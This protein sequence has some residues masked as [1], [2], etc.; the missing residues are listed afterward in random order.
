MREFAENSLQ[1]FFLQ[2]PRRKNAQ[3]TPNHTLN[4]KNPASNAQ[5]QCPGGGIPFD[6]QTCDPDLRSECPSGFTCRLV[7]T[8]L[9]L[10]TKINIQVLQATIRPEQKSICVVKAVE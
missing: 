1:K 5:I 10:I 8:I 7:I 4:F 2:T 6:Y 3:N 9:S